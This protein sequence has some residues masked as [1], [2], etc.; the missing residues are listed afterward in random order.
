MALHSQVRAAVAAATLVGNY[1]C[2]YQ[3]PIVMVTDHPV[4][5]LVTVTLTNGIPFMTF[6]FPMLPTQRRWSATPP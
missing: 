3:S 5:F 2:R 4:G 6:S 1:P